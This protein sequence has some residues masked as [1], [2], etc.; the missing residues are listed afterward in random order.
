MQ[1]RIEDLK[2]GKTKAPTRQLTE[3]EDSLKAE[4]KALQAE[5]SLDEVF[6][7]NNMQARARL[8]ATKMSLYAKTRD[9]LLEVYSNGL[10]SGIKTSVVNFTGN[11]SDIMSSII[12]RT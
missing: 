3:F 6:S 1:K 8:K 10:L 2:A 7:A 12:E 11:G 5:K 9:S 4:I